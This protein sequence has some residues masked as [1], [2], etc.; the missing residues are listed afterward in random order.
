VNQTVLIVDDHAGFRSWTRSLLETEGFSVVGETADGASALTAAR[1]LRPDLVLLDVML[2][3][4]TGFAVAERIAALADPPIVVL[5][6]SREASDFG[7]V[8]GHSAAVGFISK[9]DLT[10]SVLR[11]LLA[12]A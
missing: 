1:D 3:D 7:D 10:G 6:S 5:V 9:A 12:G 2:P 11:T 8:I 4:T